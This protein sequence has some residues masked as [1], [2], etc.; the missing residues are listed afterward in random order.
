MS[1]IGGVV[2]KRFAR[3]ESDVYGGSSRRIIVLLLLRTRPSHPDEK[4]DYFRAKAADLK[5]DP[6]AIAKFVA[7]T[8][9]ARLPRQRQ[10][11]ARSVVEQGGLA[12]GKKTA[13]RCADALCQGAG[14]MTMDDVSPSRD[15]TSDG[16]ADANQSFT[17]QIVHRVIKA[18]DHDETSPTDTPIYNGP[19]ADLVGDVH[20]VEISGPLKTTFIL[21]G[22]S[23]AS[24]LTKDVAVPADAAAEQLVFTY[25]ARPS[26]QNPP[27]AQAGHSDPAAAAPKPTQIV[28]ELWHTGNRVGA[29]HPTPRDRHD[30]VVLPCRVDKFVRRRRSKC[31]GSICATNR[32]KPGDISCCWIMHSSPIG[33]GRPGKAPAGHGAIQQAAD[34]D[35][36]TIRGRGHARQGRMGAGPAPM[37]FRSTAHSRRPI[38]RR[39][40]RSFIESG[41]EQTYLA[42][43]TG[44]PSTSTF[45]VFSRLKDDYPNTCARRL[46]AIRRTLTDLQSFGTINASA[47]FAVQVP[48]GLKWPSAPQAVVTRASSAPCT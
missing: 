19:V 12:R 10:R 45:D 34:P 2:P 14:A 17:I 44:I 5:N 4:F 8:Y 27:Q 11:S 31:S 42:S 6:A 40:R 43:T 22:K 15:K 13:G 3:L 18:S 37:R 28:R 29:E 36:L 25:A 33:A 21:R 24:R 39:R 23:D 32:R 47:T 16:S 46:V 30:F 41:L 26:Q 7:M 9:D 1:Q 35:S 20:S 48:P 38:W